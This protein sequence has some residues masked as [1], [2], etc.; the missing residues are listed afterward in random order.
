MEWRNFSITTAVFLTI[1]LA[2]PA[3]AFAQSG[4]AQAPGGA[5]STPAAAALDPAMDRL[6]DRLADSLSAHP[7]SNWDYLDKRVIDLM[8]SPSLWV[9]IPVLMLGVILWRVYRVEIRNIIQ[10]LQSVKVGSVEFVRSTAE[11]IREEIEDWV[12]RYSPGF[13]LNDTTPQSSFSMAEYPARRVP[14]TLESPFLPLDWQS[15]T[16]RLRALEIRATILEERIK[17][18]PHSSEAEPPQ[19]FV[20]LKTQLFTLLLCMGNLYGFARSRAATPDRPTDLETALYYLQKAATLAPQTGAPQRTTL[21]YAHFCIGSLK[22]LSGMELTADPALRAEAR[23]LMAEVV[24]ELMS[25]EQHEHRPSYQYHLKAY[26]LFLL[27]RVPE[28]A[29]AW[30][31]AAD[32]WRPASPKMYFNHACALTVM[33]RYGEALTQ[34]ETA[35][36]IHANQGAPGFDPKSEA[37]NPQTAAE[38]R[39][40]WPGSTNQ[41]ARDARSASGKSF[42]E[43]I[44]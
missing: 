9:L 32:L 26:L 38:L 29:D 11:E 19:G 6:I 34:L 36:T 41:A 16:P 18:S 15:A 14:A 5:A 39:V 24:D 3:I 40:F 23:S 33:A 10:N 43:I 44:A 27:G 30:G 8:T 28:A 35:V 7:E 2:T 20:R 21:G 17:V 13:H 4:G 42:D 22:G 12:F 25:A 37:V 1:V 31:M